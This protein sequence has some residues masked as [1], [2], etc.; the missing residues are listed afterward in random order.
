MESFERARLDAYFT[1]IAARFLPPE[2]AAS[3][4]IT[5]LLAERPSFVR[6]VASL[7]DVRAVL[8]K[9]KS[10]NAAA[11]RDVERSVSVDTLSRGLSP[12]R[13]PRASATLNRYLDA[14]PEDKTGLAPVLALLDTDVDQSSR[15]EFRAHATA[16]AVLVGPGNR[17]LHIRH[18]V[19]GKWLLPGGH[20]EPEDDT[21]WAA[22]LRELSEETGIPSASVTLASPIPV[23]IDVHPIPANEAK[24]EPEHQ[25]IDFRF[26][27]RTETADISALQT[28]EVTDAAWLRVNALASREL[29]RRV[30]SAL[31]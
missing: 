14:H 27:F 19:L 22:G 2:R 9:P 25:H 15:K 10:I 5:H 11:R 17:V 3:L 26:L 28:E 21:L 6:A 20:L 12:Q 4:L 8:P 13:G 7:S 16:G 1:K 29:S 18:L 23:D 31:R 24:G 30:S